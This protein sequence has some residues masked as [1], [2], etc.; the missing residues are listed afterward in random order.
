MKIGNRLPVLLVV[1]ESHF[2]GRPPQGTRRQRHGDPSPAG[3][4]KRAAASWAT[5]PLRLIPIV[6]PPK[7]TATPQGA[8]IRFGGRVIIG[9]ATQ[10]AFDGE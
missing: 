4:V 2:E 3:G 6:S 5:E 8:A 10:P 7:A 1:S 9:D